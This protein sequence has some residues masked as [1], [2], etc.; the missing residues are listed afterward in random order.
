MYSMILFVLIW[1]SIIAHTV[2]SHIYDTARNAR[3]VVLCE[4]I[5]VYS[6]LLEFRSN[7]ASSTWEE[8]GVTGGLKE[9]AGN[10][11]Y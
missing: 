11:E 7:T 2:L 4:N 10:L 1:F 8:V 9:G 5:Y 6:I 3:K